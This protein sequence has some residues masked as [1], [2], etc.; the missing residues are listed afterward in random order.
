MENQ[1]AQ[2]AP[3][4]EEKKKKKRWL[5]LLLL[6]LLLLIAGGTSALTLH[7]WGAKKSAASS[8]PIPPKIEA[9]AETIAGASSAQKLEAPKGGGAVSLTY[10]KSVRLNL[11]Q[12]KAFLVFGNPASSNQEAM[13]RLEIQ[14]TV[15]LQSGSLTPGTK[16]T[17][18]N[19]A[20][21]AEKKLTAG[22]YDGKFV[23]S[24]YDR[25]SGRWAKLNAE[26]PVTVT[27]TG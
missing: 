22:T 21:G 9:N 18:L 13:V 11:A 26:I 25:A 14:N 10:S 19:L 15:I 7:F 24:F 2:N 1:Q 12:K 8:A 20:Q 4:E 6:L 23:V 16:V 27:V 17:E 3:A 5:L